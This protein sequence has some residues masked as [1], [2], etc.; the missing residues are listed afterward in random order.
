MYA[1]HDSIIS[2]ASVERAAARIP[3][4]TAVVVPLGHFDIYTGDAFEAASEMQA[5]FLEL[6]LRSTWR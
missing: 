4:A 2:A 5:E 6:H 3:Q 1:E